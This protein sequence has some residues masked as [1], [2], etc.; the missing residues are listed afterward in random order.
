MN[1]FEPAIN[2][3][4]LDDIIFI[5]SEPETYHETR[6]ELKKLFKNPKFLEILKQ[7][8]ASKFDVDEFLNLLL[9]DDWI[10]CSIFT[11]Y[12]HTLIFIFLL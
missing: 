8:Y 2:D 12:Y 6:T 11:F 3:L 10:F 9:K 4:L 5:S 1:S 7:K